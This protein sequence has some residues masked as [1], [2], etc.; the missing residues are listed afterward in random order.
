MANRFTFGK[1]PATGASLRIRTRFS[2]ILTTI[3]LSGEPAK[4]LVSSEADEGLPVRTRKHIT[5]RLIP[6]LV[7]IY[8]LAYLDRANLGVAKLQMQND[9]GFSDAVIGL[10]AGIFFLGYLLLDIPGSLIVERWSARKWIARIMVSWGMVAT[11]MGFLGTSTFSFLRPVTQF[12]GLRLLLGI[13]E[14]GFFPGVIVYLSHWYRADDRPRAKAYFMVT[15]PLAI[16]IGIPISRWILE[17][18]GWSGLAGWRWV[19]ILEGIPPVLMGIVTLWYLTDRPQKAAWLADDQKQ[20]LIAELKA[21]EDAKVYAGRVRA[22]DALRHPQTFLLIAVF[23]LI[24]T[25]NQALIF[26]LPSIAETMKDTPVALRTIAAGL[27]YACSA[28]GILLNGMWAHRTGALR[29]HTAVPMLATAG[30][31]ALAVLAGRASTGP[32]WLMMGLF[33]LAGFTSQAYLPAF[34]TLPTI[35]LGRSAAATAVGLIC[36]GNLGG[37]AGPWLFGYLRTATGR[38]DMGLWVLAGCMLLAGTLATQI[39]VPRVSQAVTRNE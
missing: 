10:G 19:F 5:R 28:V 34:F 27:P 39:R 21:E 14:A 23:F 29:W 38:Y 36:L 8:F 31:L 15:Q 25:G 37:L 3:M 33:C 6:Y 32:G 35:L 20:W 4:A 18:V 13:A 12:Y 17:N 9:M 26:F 22:I 11:L 7:F 2:D 24:V 30:S 1:D 16:A